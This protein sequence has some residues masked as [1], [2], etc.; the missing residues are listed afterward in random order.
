MKFLSTTWQNISLSNSVPLAE[1]GL[2]QY[3][4]AVFAE[5]LCP[6]L[7]FAFT[8]FQLR[9]FRKHDLRR[10]VVGKRMGV[11]R[12]AFNMLRTRKRT[13]ES[14]NSLDTPLLA[15]AASDSPAHSSPA[16]ASASHVGSADGT[17]VLEANRDDSSTPEEPDTDTA[18]RQSQA[19][20]CRLFFKRVYRFTL[21]GLLHFSV[22]IMYL[23]AIICAVI[24]PLLGEVCSAPTLL[25]FTCA[26]CVGM[27]ASS[28]FFEP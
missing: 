7:A 4:G 14:S 21:Q 12:S 16:G 27:L 2:L 22:D 18:T 17:N 20:R 24:P 28:T 6:T 23:C 1:L 26:C 9:L 8:V 19:S 15:V 3:D 5:L 10:K 25:M 11:V 13:S